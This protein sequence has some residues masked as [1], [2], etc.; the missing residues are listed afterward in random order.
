M[1]SRRSGL[2]ALFMDGEATRACC[3]LTSVRAVTDR[4]LVINGVTDFSKSPF[5]ENR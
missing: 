4:N 1:V 2:G 5:K 3:I